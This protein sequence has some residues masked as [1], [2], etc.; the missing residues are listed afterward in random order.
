MQLRLFTKE[1]GSEECA[2]G[3]VARRTIVH[4]F[5]AANFLR[6]RRI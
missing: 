4:G 1:K 2:I 3:G 5:I 6:Q